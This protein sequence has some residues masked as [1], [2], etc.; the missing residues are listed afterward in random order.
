MDIST[1]TCINVR[2][3]L[4]VTLIPPRRVDVWAFPASFDRG[5]ECVEIQ[6]S[7]SVLALLNPS[8]ASGGDNRSDACVDFAILEDQELQ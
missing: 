2:P 3:A 7:I 4:T 5:R 1:H 6:A 8:G